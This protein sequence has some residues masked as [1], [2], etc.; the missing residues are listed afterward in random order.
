[1]PCTKFELCGEHSVK[2]WSRLRERLSELEDPETGRY[3]GPQGPEAGRHQGPAG[4]Q[5]QDTRQ[6]PGSQAEG[7]YRGDS[8]F[9]SL[10]ILI[11]ILVLKFVIK[12][13]YAV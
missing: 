11:L 13:R 6:G 12:C 1:M 2:F 9:W 3:Q 4:A 8:C 5:G 10:L 7:A